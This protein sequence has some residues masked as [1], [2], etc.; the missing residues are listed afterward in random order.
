MTTS[1]TYPATDF[2][3]PGELLSL[4][5]S[6]W[7]ENYDGYSVVQ[8]MLTAAAQLEEQNLRDLQELLDCT[9]RET[10]PLSHVERWY[11]VTFR[12]SQVNADESLVRFGDSIVFGGQRDGV[13][14]PYGDTRILGAAVLPLP[15]GLVGCDLACNRIT[16]PSLTLTSGMEFSINVNRNSISF[17]GNPFD[18]ALIPR[19]P[20]YQGAEVVDYEITLWL[21]N[22]QFDRRYLS[23]HF[24]YALGLDLPST[25]SFRRLIVALF[26]A[27]VEGPSYRTVVAT[28][29]ALLDIPIATEEGTV[30]LIVEDQ[31]HLVIATD[32]TV[33]LCPKGSTAAVAVGD[34]LSPG[35]QLVTTMTVHEFH[36]GD[37]PDGLQALAVG[38]GLLNHGYFGDLLFE[39]KT[40]PLIVEEN[41]NGYTKV[42]FELGGVPTDVDKFWDDLH[43]QGV[44]SGQT[45]AML[46]DRR[47][48]PSGQPKAGA[49]PKTINPL[50]FLLTNVWRNNV[51]LVR[52]RDKNFGANALPLPYGRWIKQTTPAGSCCVI[53]LELEAGPTVVTMDGPGDATD[54]GYSETA[55]LFDLIDETGETL[56]MPAFVD[57]YPT[58]RYETDFCV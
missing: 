42:S 39:N 4:L 36:Y 1:F 9:A 29:G 50:E 7:S 37:V 48:T 33:Y 11:P 24:G 14:F 3:K 55:E 10:V 40:V 27:I 2:Q 54:G 20:I 15:P 52:V 6:H 28:M 35:D 23:K 56:D 57:E 53:L 58:L 46:L 26:D 18:S 30:T 21:F 38:G 5:G 41:V 34:S 12:E 17:I 25:E 31:N 16:D 49:L 19:R 47:T 51:F 8:T 44:A 22:A 45:L 43:V 32:Q 13:T